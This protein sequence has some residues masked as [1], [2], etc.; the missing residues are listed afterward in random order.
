VLCH[1]K[2]EFTGQRGRV[3]T[4]RKVFYRMKG[5]RYLLFGSML[6]LIA[7]ASPAFNSIYDD[8]TRF[9]RFLNWVLT[10]VFVG[11]GLLFIVAGFGMFD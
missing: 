2:R 4:A 8:Q 6:I 3:D 7:V 5:T 9:D 11:C 1:V 10:A